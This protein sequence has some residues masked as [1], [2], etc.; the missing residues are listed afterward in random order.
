MAAGVAH[1]INNP[2]GFFNSNLGTLKNYANDLLRLIGAYEAVEPL[3]PASPPKERLEAVRKQID[4]AYLRED[5]VSLIAESIDG[6]TRVRQIVQDLRDFSRTGQVDW[7]FTDLHVGLESTIN[8]VWNELKLKA[9]VVRDYGDLPL[10]ECIPS[11]INQVFMNLLVN[12]AQAISQHGTITLR[13]GREGDQVWISVADT[14][15]GIPAEQLSKIF[16]PFFTTKPIGQGTGL[17]LSVSY[18]IVNKH[19]GHI[20]VDSQSGQGTTMTISLP[21]K[22][23]PEAIAP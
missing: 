21:I 3:L 17:G 16:D 7:T 15:I 18:G 14:G 6:T 19:G 2:I 20:R 1:E 13:S 23:V 22:R 11:Q 10:V 12:A 5:I 4:L 8:L 9:D